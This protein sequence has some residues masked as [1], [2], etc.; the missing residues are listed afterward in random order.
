M[1]A[2]TETLLENTA[3][4]AGAADESVMQRFGIESLVRVSVDIIAYLVH[5]AVVADK[6]ALFDLLATCVDLLAASIEYLCV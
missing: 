3:K 5:L 1:E 4:V 6:T 2:D